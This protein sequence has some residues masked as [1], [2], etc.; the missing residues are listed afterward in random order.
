[1]NKKIIL[2]ILFSYV[3]IQ[4]SLYSQTIK[5]NG[6]NNTVEYF[7]NSYNKKNYIEVGKSMFLLGRLILN[8][9]KLRESFA[10]IRNAYGNF[11]IKKIIEISNRKLLVNVQ[12]ER[13]STEIESFTFSFNSKHK[14]KN[15]LITQKEYS[16]SKDYD[17]VNNLSSKYYKIDSL[18]L[19]KQKY[20]GFNG[21]IAIVIGNQ[22]FYKN[23]LGLKNY[24]TKSVLNDSSVYYLASC[25]KQFTAVGILILFEKGKLKLTDTL[26]KYFPNL[27]YKNITIENL[28]THTS[29]LPD[30]ISLMASTWDKTKVAKNSD[31]L[32]SL[33][34]NKPKSYFT[35]NSAFDYCNTGYVLLSLIIEKCSNKSY[36]EFMFENI[37]NP[38]KMNHSIVNGS[39]SDSGDKVRNWAYGY[40][41]SDSL[42]RYSIADLLP[43]NNFVKYLDGIN[44]D[45]N[46]NSSID[47]LIKWELS[48]K[49]YKLISK[50]NTDRMFSR[51]T[52]KNNEKI[53]YGYGQCINDNNLFQKQVY[54]SG[55]WPGYHTSIFRL[56]NSDVSVIILTNNEYP[57]FNQLNDHILKIILK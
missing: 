4:L 38:L 55:G 42:Q 23:N 6:N 34:V 52:I 22:V 40:S 54:H 35:P 45:G 26:Q 19:Y 20:G 32:E 56:I 57:S 47:N 39:S 49:K 48:L 53:N 37:F 9:N 17:I 5:V 44:G 46:I 3:L 43:E 13:D 18:M 30:Y 36:E 33:I 8:E 31:V 16:Y 27:P 15:F 24:K 1:M 11:K 7:F 41:Y 12:S 21:S 28:L 10:E 2:T 14:I 51:Y 25:S 29:G 50:L